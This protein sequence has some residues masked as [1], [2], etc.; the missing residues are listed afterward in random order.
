MLAAWGYMNNKRLLEQFLESIFTWPV[1]K[2]FFMHL[3]VMAPIGIILCAVISHI[4]TAE[5]SWFTINWEDFW[6]VMPYVALGVI[7]L[8][9]LGVKGVEEMRLSIF[10]IFSSIIILIPIDIYLSDIKTI[11]KF[12]GYGFAFG[13]GGMGIV[14]LVATIR[15]DQHGSFRGMSDN[16]TKDN[17][18]NGLMLSMFTAVVGVLGHA[19]LTLWKFLRG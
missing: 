13:I 6:K 5:V 11:L 4:I 14:F 16:F 10:L 2:S 3:L 7:I 15:Y 9:M 1:I 17:F 12:A 18:I 19:I 8:G